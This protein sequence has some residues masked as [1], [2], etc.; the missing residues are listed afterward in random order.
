M[1]ERQQYYLQIMHNM[2]LFEGI[3]LDKSEDGNGYSIVTYHGEYYDNPYQDEKFHHTSELINVLDTYLNDHYF[4]DLEEVSEESGIDWNQEK[5]PY[6]CKEWVNF[7]DEHQNIKELCQYEYDVMDMIANHLDEIDLDKLYQYHSGQMEIPPE[8]TMIQ[9][10]IDEGN[11][12]KNGLHYL[13]RF[14]ME[15]VGNVYIMMGRNP[16]NQEEFLFDVCADKLMSKEIGFVRGRLEEVLPKIADGSIKL[17]QHDYM[18]QATAS[19]LIDKGA[20]NEKNPLHEPVEEGYVERIFQK[21]LLP[22]LN[23]LLICEQ[24]VSNEEKTV[25]QQLYQEKV[26]EFAEKFGIDPQ[27]MKEGIIPYHQARLERMLQRS[28]KEN[29]EYL[30]AKAFF[31]RNSFEE[32]GSLCA[33]T[34]PIQDGMMAIVFDGSCEKSQ[35]SVLAIVKMNFSQRKAMIYQGTCTPE[36]SEMLYEAVKK[37][38]IDDISFASLEIFCK[39]KTLFQNMI[40]LSKAITKLEENGK[41]FSFEKATIMQYKEV[42]A[43]VAN[44]LQKQ[45]QA[46]DWVRE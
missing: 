10:A 34:A 27:E 7:L 40:D 43:K 35:D 4:A 9:Q 3:E 39:G 6:S 12:L 5:V 29:I 2:L 32:D 15:G 23:R 18:I 31:R 19:E 38:K 28:E 41:P 17:F 22:A 26:N 45:P 21:S 42:L 14:P 37:L 36:Q 33:V 20:V 8:E 46:K 16:E 13:E 1:D 25:Y 24:A 30:L 11:H 44:N